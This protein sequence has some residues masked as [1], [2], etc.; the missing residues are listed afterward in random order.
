MDTRIYDIRLILKTYD[1]TDFLTNWDKELKAMNKGKNGRPYIYPNTFIE[2]CSL[3]YAFLHLP[4]HQLEGYLS[5]L[6]GLIP[7]LRSAD[8]TTLWERIV[9]LE[10]D[11]P[12]P[13]NNIA[14]AVDSTGIKVTNRGI[15]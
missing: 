8:Y 15:G 9:K 14:V 12:I 10:R 1:S 6:S 13:E 3:I 2:F 4:C 5:A 11:I 7:G